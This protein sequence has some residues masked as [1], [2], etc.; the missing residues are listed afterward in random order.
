MILFGQLLK[1]ARES[2]GFTQNHLAGL[3]ETSVQYISDLENNRRPAPKYDVMLRIIKTLDIK[4]VD[5]L[6][7]A[8]YSCRYRKE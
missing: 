8:A 4:P 5:A 6:S 2:K 3:L 7:S 1:S